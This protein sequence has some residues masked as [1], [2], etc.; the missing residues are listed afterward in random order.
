MSVDRSGMYDYER[1]TD[2]SGE[3]VRIRA[4]EVT[5]EVTRCDFDGALLFIRP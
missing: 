4:D 2:I 1:D 3:L 5:L